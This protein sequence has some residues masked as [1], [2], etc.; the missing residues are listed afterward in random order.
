MNDNDPFHGIQD[1]SQSTLKLPCQILSLSF[2]SPPCLLQVQSMS[3]ATAIC[4]LYSHCLPSAS[5][6]TH[7]HTPVPG[8]PHTT[9]VYSYSSFR[10]KIKGHLIFEA[11]LA[12]SKQLVAPTPCPHTLPLH[13]LND[14]D[15]HLQMPNSVLNTLTH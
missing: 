11:S 7:T 10:V 4:T 2:H 5:E 6:H 12:S 15:K 8:F 3:L 14:S 13:L 1:L 9:L